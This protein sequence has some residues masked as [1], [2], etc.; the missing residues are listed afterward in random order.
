MDVAD[1]AHLF[2]GFVGNLDVERFLEGHHQFDYIELVSAE[3]VENA[4]VFRDFRDLDPKLISDD[5]LNPCGQIVTHALRTPLSIGAKD[6]EPVNRAV[7][8]SPPRRVAPSYGAR[9]R[10]AAPGEQ[11]SAARWLC[12]A[13]ER[14]AVEPRR[15]TPQ[16][17]P[18][19]FG[20]S[21][22]QNSRSSLPS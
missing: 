8:K 16:P 7:F 12:Q 11:I 5:R 20:G 13:D 1:R 18:L 17:P 19:R 2:D 14:A 10:C 6:C 22:R 9:S 21:L 3:I 15:S 4:R